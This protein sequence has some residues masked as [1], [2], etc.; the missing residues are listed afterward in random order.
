MVITSCR[1][2]TLEHALFSTGLI[3]FLSQRCSIENGEDRT[4][5]Y[6][7]G[8][9]RAHGRTAT[10]R[11]G[12]GQW[13]P[14]SR[15]QQLQLVAMIMATAAEALDTAAVAAAGPH[16][17]DILIFLGLHYFLRICRA[18]FL[19]LYPDHLNVL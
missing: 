16:N 13:R 7:M 10:G 11:A 15:T 1:Q 6:H 5:R 4:R 8:A 3:L 2:K 14:R 19:G 17:N 12:G 9:A 18:N